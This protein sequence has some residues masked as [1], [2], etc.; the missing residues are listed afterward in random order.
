MVRV[1]PAAA[2]GVHLMMTVGCAAG[3]LRMTRGDLLLGSADG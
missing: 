2:A 3:H 1:R